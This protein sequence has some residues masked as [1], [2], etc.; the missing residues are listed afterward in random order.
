MFKKISDALDAIESRLTAR[1]VSCWAANNISLPTGVLTIPDEAQASCFFCINTA[2]ERMTGY[3]KPELIGHSPV[4]LEGEET[5]KE[6]V[7]QFW[8]D[9][10]REG[11][12]LTTVVNYRKDRSAIETFILGARLTVDDGSGEPA[13][14]YFCNYYPVEEVTVLPRAVRKKSKT[15][16]LH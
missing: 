9:M 3:T 7:R 10:D 12:A 16:S 14:M 13:H 2:F 15:T 6:A 4:L 8:E 5:D 11:K 1:E